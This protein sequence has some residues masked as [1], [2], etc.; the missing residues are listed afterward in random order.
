MHSSAVR[1]FRRSC[2]LVLALMVNAPS[3]QAVDPARV[4]ANKQTK[5]GLYLDAREAYELK[6]KLGD[7]VLFIDVRTR[8]EISYLGM[9]SVADAHI[10][11]FEH[12]P[13]AGWDDKNGRFKM[14]P[15]AGFE[16]E[17]ARRLASRQ[18]G[19]SDPVILICRS[20]DRT[21]RAVNFLTEQG[22]TQVY[23]VVDGFE[24]DAIA[25]GQ[26]SGQRVLNG[27]KNAGLP[28]TYKLDKNKMYLPGY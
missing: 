15:N 8:A 21:S 11:A 10:P 13:N 22:Y 17:L 23:S 24:G 3:V 2:V 20:G 27:W 19:K 16:P 6:Q 12:P 28:W 26:Q 9:P 4:P 25:D 18:L 5:A 7:K 14:D 1:I